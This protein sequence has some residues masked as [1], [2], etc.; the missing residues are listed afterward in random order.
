LNL[1]CKNANVIIE[2]INES[3]SIRSI[4]VVYRECGIQVATLLLDTSNSLLK[5]LKATEVNKIFSSLID[6]L[7]SNKIRKYPST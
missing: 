7:E 5:L 3:G 2:L 1:K 4:G 6:I